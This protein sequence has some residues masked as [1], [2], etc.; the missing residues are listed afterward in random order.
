MNFEARLHFNKVCVSI[1]AIQDFV[2]YIRAPFFNPTASR[3]AYDT[4]EADVNLSLPITSM[5]YK[6]RNRE[7]QTILNYDFY[8]EETPSMEI[9]DKIISIGFES[10]PKNLSL[11]DFVNKFSQKV[12]IKGLLER[13]YQE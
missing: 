4:I 6:F 7:S 8:A 10:A 2:P 5:I 1:L 13:Y 12:N 9:P 3:M 11:D